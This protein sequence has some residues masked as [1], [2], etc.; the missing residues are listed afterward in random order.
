MVAA[1]KEEVYEQYI[2]LVEQLRRYLKERRT[3]VMMLSAASGITQPTAAN[4]LKHNTRWPTM[5]TVM[6]LGESQGLRLVWQHADGT[7]VRRLSIDDDRVREVLR[8]IKEDERMEDL[9]KDL[10]Y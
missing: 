2:L 9:L 6:A 4:V 10:D 7:P 8:M 1:Y 3:T 5:Q